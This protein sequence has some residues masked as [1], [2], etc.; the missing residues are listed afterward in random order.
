MSE[1]T[2][3]PQV[4]VQDIANAVQ[5]IDICIQRGA[6][7]GNEAQDGGTVRNTLA[8]WVDSHRPP[9]EVPAEDVQPPKPPEED[10]GTVVEFPAEDKEG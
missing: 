5:I 8:A 2:Q 4:S 10:S 7:Q 1:E 9:A 3:V 6:I